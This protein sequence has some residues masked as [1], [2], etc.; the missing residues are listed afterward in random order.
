MASIE[1]EAAATT[2][3]QEH[4][5][6]ALETL[7]RVYREHRNAFGIHA[8]PSMRHND[9]IEVLKRDRR[10]TGA[11]EGNETGAKNGRQENA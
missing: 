8:D 1:E 2:T 9:L 3:I 11:D 10:G 4:L 5:S 7:G 6:S